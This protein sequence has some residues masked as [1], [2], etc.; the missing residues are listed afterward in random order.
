MSEWTF[1]QAG[2]EDRLAK[3]HT[4][5]MLKKSADGEEVEFII[6]VREYHTPKDPAVKFF[7][8]S[9][10]QTNQ[11]TLP[12]TPSGWGATLLEALSSCVK[13]IHKFPYEG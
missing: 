6:T 3:L 4:F 9:D 2:A 13:A 1:A 7:A 11:K 5:S 12:Y 10:K 8:S